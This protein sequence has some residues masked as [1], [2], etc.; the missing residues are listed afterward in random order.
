MSKSSKL[1]NLYKPKSE[2]EFSLISS[3]LEEAKIPFM[4][5]NSEVQDLF[6]VGR[7]GTGY[8]FVTGPMIILV[9]ENHFS[10]AREIISE[11]LGNI[12]SQTESDADLDL[13]QMA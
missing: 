3:L 4:V 6:G 1:V 12:E 9:N 2:V 13:W 11:F 5:R 7:I 8:N 10:K